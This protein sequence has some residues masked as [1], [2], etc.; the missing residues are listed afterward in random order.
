MTLCR[1]LTVR[2]PW[3]S[4]IA[5]GVKRIEIR[6]WATAYRGVLWIHA[7]AASLAQVPERYARALVLSDELP[8]GAIIARVDLVGV[9]RLGE[10]WGWC[11]ERPVRLSRPVVCAGRQGLWSVPA[12]L[13]ARLAR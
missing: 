2:Q 12:S 8:R 13:C 4:L 10:M 11:L 6:S 1:A 5:C 3:A 7:G 9:R